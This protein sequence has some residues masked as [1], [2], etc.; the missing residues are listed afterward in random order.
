MNNKALQE[1]LK[2]LPD[3]DEIVIV[4]NQPGIG[5]TPCAGV[6]SVS[7]GFDWDNHKILLR[8]DKKVITEEHLERIQK[9]S[10][11][12]EKL[13]YFYAIENKKEFMGKPLSESA[14]ARK[15]VAVKM[16]NEYMKKHVDGFLGN[17]Q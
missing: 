7:H 17:A 14:K 3:D 8:T 13:L 15:G 10:R 5:G 4:L 6:V 9:F 1:L 2:F 16:F 12:Y 11:A